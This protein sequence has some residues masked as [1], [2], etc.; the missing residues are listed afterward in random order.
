[1]TE[2][3]PLMVEASQY[4]CRALLGD[5]SWLIPSTDTPLFISAFGD[6]VF[7]NPNGSLWVLS[8]L[9]GSYAQVARNSNEYNTLNKSP[10]W[11]EQTFIAGW[12]SIAAGHGLSPDK[13]QCLGWRV[14]P[15]IG[16]KFEPSN[17]QLFDMTVY[18]S[19]MGQLHRQLQQRPVQTAKRSW[20]K[21]W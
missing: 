3:R 8:V 10:D 2:L 12:L 17:L 4:D 21:L 7:G 18:Q 15:A 13:D 19:I 6:W 1:M 20:F 16:G 5:W 11:L 9:E 14:H